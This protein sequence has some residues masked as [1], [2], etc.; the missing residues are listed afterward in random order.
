MAYKRVNWEN[1]PSTKTP[2]N[3]DNLNK[4]DEGIA[5]AVQKKGYANY[6]GFA[7]TDQTT[8]SGYVTNMELT[9]T[10]TGGDILIMSSFVAN[11]VGGGTASVGVVIDGVVKGK[12][13]LVFNDAERRYSE[14][15]ILTN[16]SAGTHTIKISASR[17]GSGSNQ[18]KFPKYY[19]RSLTA[20]EL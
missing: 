18:V 11:T 3:A 1:L 17:D 15:K 19:G 13:S 5:N 16:I 10:T 20:I 6:N 14:S 8:Q 12:I 7:T 9:I 2:V 4:M